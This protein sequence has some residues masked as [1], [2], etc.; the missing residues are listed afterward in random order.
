VRFSLNQSRENWPSNCACD[1]AER[2]ITWR[3]RDS[4]SDFRVL[5]EFQNRIFLEFFVRVSSCS[6][7]KPF[8]VRA[9]TVWEIKSTLISFLAKVVRLSKFYQGADLFQY[10]SSDRVEESAATNS[11]TPQQLT[12]SLTHGA[13]PFLRSCQLCSH[14]RTSQRFME[15]EDS[16][17]RSQEPSTGPYPEPH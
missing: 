3:P 4:L 9:S 16:L 15:P 2:A 7:I 5:F 6:N 11:L 8:E 13:E 14:S 17:P 1:Q 10:P 12:H